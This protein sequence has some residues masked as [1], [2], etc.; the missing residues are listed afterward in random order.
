MSHTRVVPP[1]PAGRRRSALLPT[2]GVVALLGLVFSAFMNVWTERLWFQSVDYG[3]VFSI[4]FWTRTVLFLVFGLAMAGAVVGSTA[5]A[6]RFRPPTRPGPA[7]SELLE[8]YREALETRFVQIMVGVGVV[9]ALFAGLS[10]ASALPTFL[11]WRNSTPFGTTDPQFGLD[12]SFYVFDLPWWRFLVGFL[13]ALC[14]FST[15]AAAVVHYV[16]GALRVAKGTKRQTSAAAQ[17]QLSVLLGL[18]ALALAASSWLDRYGYQT[19]TNPLLTGIGFTDDHSRVNGRLVVAVI[20]A[21]CAL[22]F[23]ANIWVRRWILPMTAAVL[24]VVSSIVLTTVYPAFVQGFT[25]RPNE[26]DKERPYIER[27]IAATRAAYGVDQVQITDYSAETN[28][29]AGQLR[30]DAQALPGIRL[31]DPAVVGA[32]FEQRQQVR[33]YYTFPQV[34]DVDRYRIDGQETDAVVAVRD[35]ETS[36]LE[37]QSWNNLRTV[38]THGYGLVAAYGNRNVGGEPEWIVGDLPPKG[39]LNQPEPR[40]YFGEQFDEYSV[41]GAPPGTAPIELDTPGGPTTTYS[42]KGGVPIGNLFN[43]LLYAARFADV[44]LL[45][46]GRVNEA[47]RIIYDRT[48]KE[49]V[50]AVAPWLTVDSNAYPALVDGRIVWIVDGYTTSDNYPNSHRISLQQAASDAQSRVGTTGV[51]PDE[52][53]NYIRNSV[54]AVVDAYD[55]TVKLYAWDEADPVLKTWRKAYPNTVADR[56]TIPADLKEHLRYPEDLFKVQR[57]VLGRYHVTDPMMWF[58]GND[59]WQIPPDPVTPSQKEN[60][61]YLSVKWPGEPAPV[62]SQTTVF[63]PRGRA[64]LAAYMAV[65]ADA[66]SPGY[67]RLRIL[68]MSDQKQIAGPGQTFNEMNTHDEVARRLLSY[69]QTAE[70]IHG[71]LLTLPVGGG[72]LYVQ[73]V[74]TK[75]NGAGSYPT[76]SFVVVRFGEKVGVGDTLKEAL[77]QVFAGDA[78][79]DTGENGT[80]TPPPGS[81]AP[82]QPPGPVDQAAATAAVK[83]A[84]ALFVS[85]DKALREGDLAA[86]K[87]RT[88]EARAAVQ[89]AVK[90]LGG[91]G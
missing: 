50:Q 6:Y 2:L 27:H 29:T 76:L 86:Y 87:K 89:K 15:L 68:R 91:G 5:L 20:T 78:G 48:P 7:A 52:T 74:Y 45:L 57:D 31:V 72:L 43:R 35:L 8:R 82:A 85:A 11:A 23:F 66:S 4:G 59:Q 24:T 83:E 14:V 41:V 16:M 9:V 1:K 60:P 12:L 64:N 73:P 42:G 30:A 3:Q 80:Q 36:G 47:S 38:Y 28:T 25:V 13:I 65:D 84:E 71:N 75:K 18:T 21:I 90:A 32:T 69:R 22:L 53:V 37:S 88:D 77:D 55:G 79:A 62:F 67:G 10:A 39:K 58:Q 51:A 49:R 81:G 44:N 19:T 40:I 46:S 70:V 54:K 17:A 33:G 26:P 61:F 63:V 56:S 34:L